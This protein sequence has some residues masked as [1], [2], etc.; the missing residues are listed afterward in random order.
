LYF[1]IVGAGRIGTSLA[2]WLV[3]ADH[4]V[5]VIDREAVNCNAVD[6]ELGSVSVVGDGT[7]AGVLMKAGANRAD[8]L[9]AVTGRDEDNLVACQM[10]KH[11]FNVE[12]TIAL[13]NIPDHER[14]F[15]M[16][17]I[18]VTINA[19][20]LVLN[21]VQEELGGLLVEEIETL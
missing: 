8:V 13:A 18:G 12:R 4:E 1:V 2:K 17:G 6:E 3:A 21:K 10:A 20:E 19:T 15:D 14:L 7:E 9:I 11:R 5:A 16:L